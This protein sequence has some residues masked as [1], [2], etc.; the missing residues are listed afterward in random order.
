MVDDEDSLDME[1]TGT[2]EKLNT[3]GM[4]KV[5]LDLEV[6]PPKRVVKVEKSKHDVDVRT[7]CFRK[8]S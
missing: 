3:G 1:C 7:L 5:G 2:V 4:N 8:S 6:V